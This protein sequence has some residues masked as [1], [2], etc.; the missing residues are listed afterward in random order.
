MDDQILD[1]RSP[2]QLVFAGIGDWFQFMSVFVNSECTMKLL[3]TGHEQH[4]EKQLLLCNHLQVMLY[5][6]WLLDI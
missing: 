4:K 6:E 1:A 5:S 3:T 2:W